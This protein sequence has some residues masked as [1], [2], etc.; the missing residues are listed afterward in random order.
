[1]SYFMAFSTTAVRRLSN[2]LLRSVLVKEAILLVHKTPS[3]GH[4]LLR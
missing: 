4:V 2:T 1:M 3:Y